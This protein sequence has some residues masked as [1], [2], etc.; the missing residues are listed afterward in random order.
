MLGFAS[1]SREKMRKKASELEE[2]TVFFWAKKKR[3][4]DK[5]FEFSVTFSGEE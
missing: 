1:L 3:E 4:E 2:V 5:S